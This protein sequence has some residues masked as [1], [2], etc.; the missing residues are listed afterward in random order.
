MGAKKSWS[1]DSQGTDTLMFSVPRCQMSSCLGVK[2]WCLQS[3]PG[4]HKESFIF[5]GD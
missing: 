1:W 4:V 5:P 3:E 2:T